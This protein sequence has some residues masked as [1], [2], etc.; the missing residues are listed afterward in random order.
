[1]SITKRMTLLLALLLSET[2]LGAQKTIIVKLT[3]PD[4]AWTIDIDEVH[5]VKNELWVI[6]TLSRDPDVVGAQVVSTAMARVRLEAPDLPIKRFVIGEACRRKDKESHTFI[7][8]LKE[9]QKALKSGK[10]LYRRA[11]KKS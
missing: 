10:L 9:I 1:M 2:A 11:K 4:S 7:K 5:K 8:N 6:S 3:V